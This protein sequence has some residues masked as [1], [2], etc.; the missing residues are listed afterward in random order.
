[1][2]RIWNNENDHR[3]IEVTVAEYE[4][5]VFVEDSRPKPRQACSLEEYLNRAGKGKDIR[6]YIESELLREDLFEIEEEVNARL[7]ERSH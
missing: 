2:K 7:S 6:E 4:V 3:Y 1:M 5:T